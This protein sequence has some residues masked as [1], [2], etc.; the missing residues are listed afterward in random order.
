MRTLGLLLLALNLSA[1]NFTQRGFLDLQ[2]TTYP[3]TAS[4]DSGRSVGAALLR[5]EPAYKVTSR[6]RLAASFEARTD[7]HRQVERSGG[8]SWQDRGLQRPA[9]AVR[10]LSASY[11]RGGVTVELGKQFIRWGK[12]DILNP[13]DRFAPRDFLNV[14]DNEFLAVTA[15]RVT[16]EARSSDTID[17]VYAPRFTPSRSPLMNQRWAVLPGF[18][19]GITVND[20]GARLPGGPQ[21]GVRWSH[22]G[23]VFEHTLTFYEGFNHLPS[24]DGW[25]ATNPPRVEV[26]RFYPKMRMAGGSVAVPLRWFTVKSETAYFTSST[27]QA[28]EYLQYGVQLERQS[29]EWF[30]VGGYAGEYV[31]RAVDGYKFAP[32]RGLARAFLGRAQY[33]I[34]VNRSL[35]IEGAVR[36]NGDGGSLKFEYTQAIGQHL[37]ATGSFTLIRGAPTDFLGMYRRNSR[38]VVSLRYSL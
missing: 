8:L 3:Q 2:F 22:L 36:R 29:G 13:T 18:L 23:S 26:V 24:F 4:L 32:D 21:F 19:Q 31:T 14:M 9:F 37:R 34:D 1:Q 10:Q 12:S 33:T 28:E 5:Y 17:F 35:A 20:T 30:L 38:G 16:W 6:L 7:S 25:I 27:P 15:A 11:H